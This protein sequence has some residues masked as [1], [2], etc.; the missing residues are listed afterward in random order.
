MPER[1][2]GG[3]MVG[4]VAIFQWRHARCP[5]GICVRVGSG[6]R[7]RNALD[8]RR[9]AGGEGS[10]RGRDG[11][12]ELLMFLKGGWWGGVAR[13]GGGEGGGGP[14]LLVFGTS[15]SKWLSQEQS[16]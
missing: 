2:G 1:E 7:C 8:G 16:L 3:Y 11:G 5:D 13:G 6:H 9:R 10:G 12:D 15:K 14:E 4:G